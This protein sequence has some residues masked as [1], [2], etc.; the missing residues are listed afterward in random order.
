MLVRYLP[1]ILVLGAAVPALAPTK[2]ATQEFYLGV[3]HRT[4]GTPSDRE[5]ANGVFDHKRKAAAASQAPKIE[6][7]EVQAA[8]ARVAGV[9][10][11]DVAARYVTE[12]VPYTTDPPPKT[13]GPP[14][15]NPGDRQA[16]PKTGGAPVN[17]SSENKALPPGTDAREV[18]PAEAFPPERIDRT[19]QAP[20]RAGVDTQTIA[21]K[22][23]PRSVEETKDPGG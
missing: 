12:A 18:R 1:L 10:P 4:D 19:P 17:S 2:A 6:L 21:P 14:K 20:S 15:P 3:G 11:E 16:R 13:A 7:G 9:R 23:D 22:D 8:P 5:A